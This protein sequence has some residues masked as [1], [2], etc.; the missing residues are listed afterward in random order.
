MF[1]EHSYSVD[2]CYRI[3][4][5]HLC[6]RGKTAPPSHS[7]LDM[8]LNDTN[9]VPTYIRLLIVLFTFIKSITQTGILISSAKLKLFHSEKSSQ[10]NIPQFTDSGGKASLF[11]GKNHNSFQELDWTETCAKPRQFRFDTLTHSG[12]FDGDWDIRMN[13]I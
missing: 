8:T 7:V 11:V 12:S 13:E 6:K 2:S 5:L 4:R 1:Q 3:R 10:E 9:R